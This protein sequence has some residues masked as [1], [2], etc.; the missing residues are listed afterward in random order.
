LSDADAP[1]AP[2]GIVVRDDVAYVADF[3]AAHPRIAK[4]DAGTGVYQGELVATGFEATFQPRGL[5]FG[6]DGGLYVS[7]SDESMSGSSDPPGYI[8]R[9]DTATGAFE[10]VARNDGDGQQEVDEVDLHNPEG[11]VFGPDGRIYVTSNRTNPDV[12]IDENTTIVVIDPE[13]GEQLDQVVLGPQETPQN[14]TRIYAQAILFGPDGKLFI[15][16]ANVTFDT[17]PFPTP[18]V[19]AGG[20]WTYDPATKQLSSLIT[21][22]LFDPHLTFPDYLTFGQTDPATLQYVAVADPSLELTL[23]L[24]S[25]SENGENSR[26]TRAIIEATKKRETSTFPCCEAITYLS[27]IR[28]F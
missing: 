10:V 14:P 12:Q 20:V 1:F 24:A 8:L 15:P 7:V 3:N 27:E 11:L 19:Y 9:F 25:I 17:G 18:P 22:S 13:S 4:Y 6:P 21:P 16:I 5:V 23:A 28:E 2:T 26:L